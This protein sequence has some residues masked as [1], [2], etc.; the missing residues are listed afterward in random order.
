VLI[1][2]FIAGLMIGRTPDYLGKKLDAWCGTWAII[3]I[4]VPDAACLLSSCL[5]LHTHAGLSSIANNG[6]HGFSEILYCFGEAVQNNGSAFAG[7][8][9][10]TPFYNVLVGIDIWIGRFAPIIAALAIVGRLASK[11][12]VPASP[13]TLPTHGWTFGLT[14]TGVI[15]AV[16]A[17]TFFP[18]LCLGPI[19]E[20][21]LMLMGKTF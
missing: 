20:H 10:N 17:L 19:I 6:P 9:A 16:T 8:N 3:G 18:A 15:V 7:L 5:A 4:C 12:T 1:A 14:L 21:G 11:K 2:V 13:G